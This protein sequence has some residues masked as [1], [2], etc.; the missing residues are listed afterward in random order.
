MYLSEFLFSCAN[1]YIHLK[2]SDRQ[3]EETQNSFQLQGR[4]MGHTWSPALKLGTTQLGQPHVR[5]AEKN[6]RQDSFLTFFGIQLPVPTSIML[7]NW[8]RE[9]A[10]TSTF[11]FS[12]VQLLNCVRLFA[13]PWT[14]ARQ[15][16]LSI[17]SSWNLLTLI[18]IESVM[19]SN[20]LILCRPLLLPPSV[21]PS[22]RVFS[23]ESVLRIG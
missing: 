15:V 14:A 22:I 16:S 23:N 5:S 12:S 9:C 6:R 8:V 20:H 17:T 3:K 2:Y 11:Q 4:L 18:S 13:T 21:F 19:P 10:N 7:D 1:I